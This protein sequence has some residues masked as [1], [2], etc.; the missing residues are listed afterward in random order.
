[1]TIDQES[2]ARKEFY[3]RVLAEQAHAFKTNGPRTE[4]QL[5]DIHD[6]LAP[7]IDAKDA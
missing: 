2:T 6:A 4:A 5:R 7:L 1:M 3:K